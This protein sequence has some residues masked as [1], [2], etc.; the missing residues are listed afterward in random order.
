MYPELRDISLKGL[1]DIGFDGYAIGG[2][3]VGEPKEE[4]L[5]IIEHITPSM[6]PERP[7]YLMGVGTPEDLVEAVR[8]GIDMFDCV[9]PTRNAR[10]GHIF[11]SQGVIR[12]RNSRYRTD[13]APLDENCECYTCR[14][15]SRSYLYHLD[16][17]GEILGAR[18]N[19][20]HNLSFYQTLMQGMR[21]AIENSELDSFIRE[22]YGKRAQDPLVV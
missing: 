22:F 6:P 19:T 14:R 9:L 10:N 18:L 4:M 3:S 16:K 15:Y 21:D 20:I 1:L 8:R 2:L 11:T 13:M 5:R 17:T 7:R 12:I